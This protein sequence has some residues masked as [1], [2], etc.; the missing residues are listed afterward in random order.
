[1]TILGLGSES[2]QLSP[3]VA[4]L[5]DGL[6]AWSKRSESKRRLSSVECENPP[7]FQAHML[8]E[9]GDYEL[10]ELRRFVKE[11]RFLQVRGV[12]SVF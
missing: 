10:S 1:M 12:E 3:R 5:D 7:V 9:Y 11:G 8:C 6:E 2:L 4:L